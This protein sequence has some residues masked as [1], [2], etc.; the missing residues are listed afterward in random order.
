MSDRLVDV[1]PSERTAI[2]T[3]ELARGATLTPTDVMRLTECAERTAYDVLNRLAR[4][5]PLYE[6][7]GRWALLDLGLRIE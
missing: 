5:L 3:L 4:V 7:G 2:V 6:D 1:T